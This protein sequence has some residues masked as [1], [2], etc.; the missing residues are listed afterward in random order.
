VSPGPVSDVGWWVECRLS[1][2]KRPDW[3]ETQRKSFVFAALTP[4]CYCLLLAKQ[5]VVP[6]AREACTPTPACL[7]CAWRVGAQAEPGACTSRVNVTV[8]SV[9][10]PLW[11]ER[12]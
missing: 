6:A 7:S 1:K 11:Q 3:N 4:G 10:Y 8:E 5:G 9:N 12:I 2:K